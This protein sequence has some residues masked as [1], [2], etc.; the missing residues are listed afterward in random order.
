MATK[1]DAAKVRAMLVAW[2]EAD[3]HTSPMGVGYRDTPEGHKAR[4]A[5]EAAR[6]AM[7]NHRQ[8]SGDT[9]AAWLMP[10]PGGETRVYF[11]MDD[12]ICWRQVV[13]GVL[14]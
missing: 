4:D 2:I 7:V 1:A 9:R 5:Y 11:L 14:S 6:L 8:A 13:R 12:E 10:M 3:G